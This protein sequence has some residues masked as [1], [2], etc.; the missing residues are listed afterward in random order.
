MVN[1]GNRILTFATLVRVLDP[2]NKDTLMVS[3]KEPIEKCRARPTDVQKP[4]RRRSK[5]NPN[6]RTHRITNS[7]WTARF[8]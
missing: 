2:E 3:G 8:N 6:R 7:R 5:A 1:D 4:G